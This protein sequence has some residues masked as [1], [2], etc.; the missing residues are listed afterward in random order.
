MTIFELFSTLTLVG[1]RVA[2]GSTTGWNVEMMKLLLIQRDFKILSEIIFMVIFL[3]KHINEL[4][5][6]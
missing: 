2:S 5:D 6:F 1:I 4:N 3:I